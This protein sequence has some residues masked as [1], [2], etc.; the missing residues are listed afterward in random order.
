MYKKKK[1]KKN[2]FEMMKIKN[3][4]IMNFERGR[5][6]VWDAKLKRKIKIFQKFSSKLFRRGTYKENLGTQQTCVSLGA[7]HTTDG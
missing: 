1:K 7:M 4:F 2:S 3:P 6:I 5:H